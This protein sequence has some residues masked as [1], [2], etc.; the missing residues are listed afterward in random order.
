M[1]NT[2]GNTKFNPKLELYGEALK[3]IKIGNLFF[4]TEFIHSSQVRSAKYNMAPSRWNKLDVMKKFSEVKRLDFS[5]EY[6]FVVNCNYD[7]HGILIGPHSY[8]AMGRKTV[9]PAIH[10]IYVDICTVELEMKLG[11]RLEQILVEKNGR[12]Y[13]ENLAMVL[14]KFKEI[15][16]KTPR[17]N[18]G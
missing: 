6:P 13:M 7:R 15:K 1:R 14:K 10:I 17:E 9:D 2:L 11:L 4:S 8:W 3:R 18:W 12:S 5:E 16:A